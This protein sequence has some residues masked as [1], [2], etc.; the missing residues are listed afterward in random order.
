MESQ[1]KNLISRRLQGYERWDEKTLTV[2]RQRSVSA[3]LADGSYRR[4]S[5]DKSNKSTIRN[6]ITNK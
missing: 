6:K 2:E 3:A 4:Y 5:R 1:E